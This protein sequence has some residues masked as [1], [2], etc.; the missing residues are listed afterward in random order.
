MLV[1]VFDVAEG[2][3][4]ELVLVEVDAFALLVVFNALEIDTLAFAGLVMAVTVG[5]PR[6]SEE[7]GVRLNDVVHPDGVEIKVVV[8]VVAKRSVVVDCAATIL[9]AAYSAR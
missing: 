1:V 2:V 7:T 6:V 9:G 8:S 3:I 5:V 4:L